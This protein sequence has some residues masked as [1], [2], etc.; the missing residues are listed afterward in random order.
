MWAHFIIVMKMVSK[1]VSVYT[2]L[3]L[4][5]ADPKSNAT[6]GL[7]NHTTRCVKKPNN[8][9]NNQATLCYGETK[10]M[11]VGQGFTYEFEI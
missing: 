8:K 9:P 6:S 2:V 5:A 1:K 3:R 4:I 7:N 11:G 10:L